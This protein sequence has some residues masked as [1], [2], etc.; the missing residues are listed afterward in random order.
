MSTVPQSIQSLDELRS[1]IHAELCR[2]ENLVPEQF[3][4]KQT[5]LVVRGRQCGLQFSLQG[6]RSVRLGAIW[7]AD[8]NELYLYDTRGERY[9]R[10]RLR[11]R[12]YA[13]LTCA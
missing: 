2:K 12:I 9:R 1:F 10:L 4:I 8:Q 7:A 11:H 6:P 3:P 13:D 5:T